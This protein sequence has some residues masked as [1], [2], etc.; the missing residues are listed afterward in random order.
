[1][2]CRFRPLN[3][4]NWF[5]EIYR[6]LNSSNS[7]LNL[8]YFD[9]SSACLRYHRSKTRLVDK[10]WG[11]TLIRRYLLT[12][13]FFVFQMMLFFEKVLLFKDDPIQAFS[14][15]HSI[16]L[17]HP[18]LQEMLLDLL[19]PEEALTIGEE[20]HFQHS[21]RFVIQALVSSLRPFINNFT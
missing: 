1:M 6:A 17:G 19:S 11:G 21:L 9:W 13:H 12:T 4:V 16:C 10:T 7:S 18:D 15:L 20:V 2:E 5:Y 14:E 3:H 8:T